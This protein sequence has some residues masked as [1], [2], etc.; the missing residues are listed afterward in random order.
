MFIQPND[1]NKTFDQEQVGTVLEKILSNKI[2]PWQRLPGNLQQQQREYWLKKKENDK[3]DR[4]KEVEKRESAKQTSARSSQ[5]PA[6]KAQDMYVPKNAKEKSR[7]ATTRITTRKVE[8]KR[9]LHIN[10][11]RNPFR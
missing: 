8:L 4:K 10:T 9:E 11:E 1:Q 7:A 6:G 5:E 3:A 2:R